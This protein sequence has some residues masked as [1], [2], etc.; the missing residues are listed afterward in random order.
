[1]AKKQ[2]Q[3]RSTPIRKIPELQQQPGRADYAGKTSAFFNKTPLI[4]LIII[5][6]C[7]TVYYRTLSYDYTH[8]DDDIMILNNLAF[9]KD[10]SNLPEA[11][12][13]D[14]WFMHKGIELYR[15][16][17]NISYMMDAQIGNDIIF[18]THLTNL[19]LH[20]LCCIAIFFLLTQLKFDRKYAFLG[21]LVYAVHYLFLHAVIWIP[22]RGDLLLSL[23]SFLSMLTFLLLIRTDKW[24]YYAL[25]IIA[26]SLA[27]FSKETAIML[28]LLFI[29]YLLLF[30]RKSFF[31]KK[32]LI[33]AGFYALSIIAF[34]YLRELSVIKKDQ[35]GIGNFFLNLQTIPEVIQKF[36]VPVNFC[37]MPAFNTTATIIGMMI[38]A[39]FVLLFIFRKKL[40]NPLIMF[41]LLWFICFLLPGMI[42]RPDFTDFSYEYL[43]HRDYLPSLGILMILLSLVQGHEIRSKNAFA[44]KLILFGSLLVLIYL[45]FLNF[46]L[47]GI[48]KNAVRYSES[49]ITHNPS[50]AQG[51]FIHGCEMEKAKQEDAALADFSNA[52]KYHPN[53]FEARY[54]RA[55]ILYK[56]KEYKKTLGDLDYI[57]NYKPG[58]GY[59]AYSLRG[60]VRSNVGDYEGAEKDFQTALQLRPDYPEAK[61]NLDAVKKILGNLPGKFNE[62][63][64][65]YA[66]NGN[67]QEALKSFENAYT[68]DTANYNTLLNIGNCKLAL[69]NLTGACEDWKKA[70]RRGAPGAQEMI[71]HYCK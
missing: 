21:A 8:Y 70:A 38:I 2:V 35:T 66:K 1:M 28:P 14:A 45:G 62:D 63:G 11:I 24:Y 20:I 15:P 12:V 26:F 55:A 25:N 7:I 65:N 32:H 43:D 41:S 4:L 6:A 27:M 19:V 68:K 33:L 46:M 9:L 39:G 22:A 23:F 61:N 64:L 13:L 50:C 53:L 67:Y 44:G 30:L 29:I 31:R 49:A 17:Q 71:N 36:F 16:L 18:S 3:K 51:Y 34:Y 37:T 69:G 54:N 59:D 57:I 10:L 40:Y 58:Y 47:N 52:V 5:L 48:Y 56:K 60:A 42:Y